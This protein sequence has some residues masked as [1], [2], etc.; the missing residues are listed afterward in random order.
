MPLSKSKKKVVLDEVSKIANGAK[1]VVF[2]N[3]HGLTV[4]N[5][6]EMRKQ[7]RKEGVGYTVAK[8]TLAKKAFA[9]RT[10]KGTMP[11]LDGELALVYGVDLIAPA[12]E[13]HAFQKKFD[14]KI[15][16]L[17]GVFDG[18]YKSK[19]EMTAIAN[20]PGREQLYGMFVNLIN[21]PIQRIVIVLDQIAKSKA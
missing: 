6:T 18:E 3:F 5:S 16:I 14:G 9:G 21:S 13:V 17:G 12:R 7:L 10:V 15:A 4:G 2:V 1:T 8:K 11:E 20:I 19:E